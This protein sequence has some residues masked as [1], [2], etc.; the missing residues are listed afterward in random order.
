MPI[1]QTS[2]RSKFTQSKNATITNLSVP[3][4][5]TEVSHSLQSGLNSVI[6]RSRNRA[7]LQIAFVA[8]ESGTNYITIPRGTSLSLESLEFSGETLYVQSSAAGNTVEILELH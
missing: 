7:E 1:S 2:I 5:A 8:T 6:I 4:A 3:L